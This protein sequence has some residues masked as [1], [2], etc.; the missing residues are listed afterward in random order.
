M[1]DFD[2]KLKALLD[3]GD[4]NFIGDAI[5]ETG[6]YKTALGSFRGQGGGM[7]VTAWIGIFI[8]SGIMILSLWQMFIA[9]TVRMQIIWATFAILGNTAQIGLKLWFNMQ[10]NR[11][12]LSKELRRIQL[13][14]ASQI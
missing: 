10:L 2:T 1:T 13:A 3:E 8:F 11:V 14:V 9:E 4:A 7:R 6:Y 12:A 5:D